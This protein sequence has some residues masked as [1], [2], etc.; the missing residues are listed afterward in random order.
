MLRETA[1]VTQ[2]IS[3]LVVVQTQNKLACSSCQV[4]DTCGNGLVE[5][6]LSGK[7]FS[8]Q[9]IN[10]LDAQ[11]GDE[12]IIEIKKS[13]ITIASIVTYLIPLLSFILFALAASIVSFSENATIMISLVGLG[14]GFVVTNFYNRKLSNNEFYLPK[15][16]SIVNTGSTKDKL[17]PQINADL[18]ID[19]NEI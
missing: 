9:I 8:S 16:V 1:L 17:H 13:S 3:D 7:I 2:I 4:V 5:K 6:Y 11:V 10:R 18:T 12:V 19:F 15:M 14:L